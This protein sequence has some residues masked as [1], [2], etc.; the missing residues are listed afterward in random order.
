MTTISDLSN[1][2][3]IE[4]S[5]FNGCTNLDA[6][7]SLVNC[8]S[9]DNY[10]FYPGDNAVSKIHGTLY[11]PKCEKIGNAAFGKCDN[12]SFV[13]TPTTTTVGS[14]NALGTNPNVSIVANSEEE[15]ITYCSGITSDGALQGLNGLKKV[16]TITNGVPDTMTATLDTAS[17]EAGVTYYVTASSD[18]GYSMDNYQTASA[19]SIS[20]KGVADG[21]TEAVDKTNEL[22]LKYSIPQDQYDA[23]RTYYLSTD[24]A[25][26]IDLIEDSGSYTYQFKS[27][28]TGTQTIAI[29][30]PNVT[31]ITVEGDNTF[32][33]GDTTSA[34]YTATVNPNNAKQA[35]TWSSNNEAVLKFENENSGTATIVGLGEA[36]ITATATDGSSVKG[37]LDI[38]V[39]KAD[40]EVSATGFD[41]QYDGQSHSISVTGQP[42]GTTVQY[43]EGDYSTVEDPATITWSDENP[44]YTDVCSRTVS[45]KVTDPNG[46]Y[47]DAI[48]TA[49]INISQADVP[50]PTAAPELDS[51]TSDSVTLKTVEGGTT[52]QGDE[53][54][55]QYGIQNGT[56]EITWQ[57]TNIFTGLER[58]TEYTFYIRNHITDTSKVVD[59]TENGNSSV[60]QGVKITTEDVTPPAKGDGYTINYKEETITLGAGY[61]AAT[62][63][64]FAEG[65]ILNSGDKITPGSMIYVRYAATTDRPASA[66]TENQIDPR[67]AAPTEKPVIIQ[68]AKMLQVTNAADGQEYMFKETTDTNL[69]A[70]FDVWQD[71]PVLIDDDMQD[72]NTYIVTTR[73]K[74]TDDSF[75]SAEISSNAYQAE[76]TPKNDVRLDGGSTGTEWKNKT[77]T[78]DTTTYNADT[79]Y[80]IPFYLKTSGGDTYMVEID[81]GDMLFSYN[82]G[83]WDTETLSYDDPSQQG[84]TTSFD[85]TNN[86]VTVINRSSEPIDSTIGM[87]IDADKQTELANL[88]FHLT[89]NNANSD[90]QD[91]YYLTEAT[92]LKSGPEEN[93]TTAYVNIKDNDAKPDTSILD[94]YSQDM[95]GTEFGKITVTVQKTN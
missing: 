75:A 40:M 12:L 2:T 48:G 68:T 58:M 23:D 50:V 54:S 83:T 1:C 46:N 60:S 29:V 86:Q 14:K 49:S 39:G 37:T 10:A 93:S 74:A 33:Y 79:P 78:S 42:E 87:T 5:V 51:K 57:D 7:L 73:V 3:K 95:N 81:W 90:N 15:L 69:T 52:Q 56:G 67:P 30:S 85:G 27:E 77:D 94:K 38:T 70:T 18:S 44:A 63:A 71:S 72:G 6:E 61:E 41:G 4:R 13:I 84:W 35:V 9:I 25:T 20:V 45:Y 21:A 92:T 26:P 43:Y 28:V 24:T 16:A 82:F 53:Y 19:Y 32:T 34:Q 89:K 66:G 11:L 17:L 22:Q 91:D 47:N 55:V 8:T 64:S 88:G 36:T 31:S 65:T 62:D 76:K 80:E 59:Y